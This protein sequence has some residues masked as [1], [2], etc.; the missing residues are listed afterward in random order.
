MIA[1][2]ARGQGNAGYACYGL[3]AFLLSAAPSQAQSVAD[4]YRGKTIQLLIGYTTG[5]NYDLSA[6]ILARHMGRHIP[7]NPN[8]VPQNMAGAGS[9]RL[10]NVLYNVAPKDG[11][12]FGMIGRGVPMEPLLGAGV[13]KFDARRYTWI[14]SVSN[15]TAVC[16]TWHTSKVRTWN[17]A[18]TIPF[19]SGGQGPGSDDDLFTLMVR[20]IFD[21]KVRLVVGYPGGNEINLAMERGEVDGRCGWSWGAVKTTRLDW[22]TGKQINLL[23]QIALQRAS[24]LPD[25][26]LIMDFATNDRQRQILRLLLSRQQMAWPFVAP[27]DVPKDRAAA[28]R[29]AFD[30][31]M[32][33]PEY[34]AEAKQR[35]LEVNPMSGAAIDELLNELYASPPEVIAAT[36]AAITDGAK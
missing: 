29:A 16:V 15:E 11:A 5:G 20:N 1:R 22:V 33:D 31:T 24:D 30:A 2:I 14:G 3:L 8:L 7:G 6:R 18:L 34:L 26:P 32:C 23:F 9:V 35:G 28:L 21:V 25:V 19:L 36:K 10:A 17:D 4:F 27:P 12:T 13:G